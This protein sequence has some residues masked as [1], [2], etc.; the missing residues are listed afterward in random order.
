MYKIVSRIISNA[1]GRAMMDHV[2][3]LRGEG[4]GFVNE[5]ELL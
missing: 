1:I 4:E 5:L 3:K 2:I